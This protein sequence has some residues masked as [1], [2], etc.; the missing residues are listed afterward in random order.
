MVGFADLPE[1][2][3]QSIYELDRGHRALPDGLNGSGI[4]F[5]GHNR[6]DDCSCT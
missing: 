3:D 6:C 5:Q 4:Y 1:D 2:Y